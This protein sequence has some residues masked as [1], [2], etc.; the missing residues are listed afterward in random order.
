MA[1]NTPY[2][3]VNINQLA[4]INQEDPWFGLGYLLAHNYNTNYDQRGIDK[5]TDAAN[6]A[7][8]D[9]KARMNGEATSEDVANV[10]K[11]VLDNIN[12]DYM[13][14]S[15]YESANKALDNL[16]GDYIA[17][18]SGIK[19]LK[20]TIGEGPISMEGRDTSVAMGQLPQTGN[21]AYVQ[22][23]MP[24]EDE[25]KELAAMIPAAE[26]RGL[27]MSFRG[28]DFKANFIKEQRALG[29]PDYQ[30]EAAYEAIAPRVDEMDAQAK[31]MRSDNVIKQL[32]GMAP[33][34][35]NAERLNLINNLAKDNPTMATAFLKDTIGNRDFWAQQAAA[36]K[37]EQAYQNRVALENAKEDRA[38]RRAA[39][40]IYANVNSGGGGRSGSAKS[41]LASEEFK[42][43]DKR[44]AE[45]EQM[46]QMGEQLSP[47]V[48]AEYNQLK[49][50]VDSV[51]QNV[52]GNMGSGTGQQ[53]PW[54]DWNN[55]AQN[56]QEALQQGVPKDQILQNAQILV[57]NGQMPTEFY[58]A[59]EN[60]FSN[61]DDAPQPAAQQQG[62]PLFPNWGNNGQRSGIAAMSGTDA[63]STLSDYLTGKKHFNLAHR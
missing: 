12:T 34:M 54:S 17:G 29:R 55:V 56:V 50:Y 2:E 35:D 44:V 6:K 63:L 58:G 27:D 31:M 5:A 30:I 20:N 16:Q 46:M 26:G 10:K 52:Y 25:I 37:A 61:A 48:T 36:A 4:R 14:L 11:S 41:P 8:D 53:N 21:N 24:N 15:N 39:A 47:S 3:R 62:E 22:R 9:Y 32:A 42:Y 40:K 23:T 13:D 7:L 49:P 43:A 51:K 60:S 33:T 28:D 59:I 57:K 19:G 1:L 38:D 45:I 18:G